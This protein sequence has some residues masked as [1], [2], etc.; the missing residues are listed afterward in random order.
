MRLGD[1]PNY[2]TDDRYFW[3]DMSGTVGTTVSTDQTSYTRNQSVSIRPRC[4]P[5]RARCNAAVSFT[6]KKSNG[7]LVIGTATTGS[8]GTTLYKL[9]LE[10]SGRE[11]RGRRDC[12]V[13][14]RRHE[15]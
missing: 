2:R 10:R 1:S 12:D 7:A 8:N 4:V 14:K 3:L 6:V 15:L 13:R 9:W 11:L 5:G